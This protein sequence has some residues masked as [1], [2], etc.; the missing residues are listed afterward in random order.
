MKN[1]T[2]RTLTG[3]VFTVTLIVAFVASQYS[4]LAMVVLIAILCISE[5]YGMAKAI[6]IRP[7][8]AIGYTITL[9]IIALTFLISKD[10]I[11]P[12]IS[13][14]LIPLL[15]M[16]FIVQLYHKHKKPIENIG[17]TFLS[18]I[19]VAI[20]LSLLIV[21]SQLGETYDHQINLG[22]IFMIWASDTFAY[23]VGMAIGQ[24]PLFY[25]ISPKKSWEGFIGGLAAALVL[26][27]IIAKYWIILTPLQW[28]VL[29]IIVSITGVWGDLV[30]SMFKRAVNVKDSGNILPGHGG[31]L[32]RFD[33]LL[34]V[35]PFAFTYVYL[36]LS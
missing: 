28:G 18:I 4:M 14:V 11:P 3:L 33:S 27:Q 7:L 10:I 1:L 9:L 26:S 30:E 23:L 15:S 12:E 31:V 6:E 17:Y 22:I 34:M 19:H 13:I 16:A 24:N 36:I 8:Y 35:M 5:H 25:R 2:K 21:L 29:S 32:D 20:P